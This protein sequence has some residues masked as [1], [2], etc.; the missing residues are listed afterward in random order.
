MLKLTKDEKASRY[1]ALQIAIKVTLESYRR[2]QKD[3]EIRF[4]EA[5]HDGIVGAYTKGQADAFA[6]IVSDLER[7]AE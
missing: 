7:W 3:S 2:R 6:L 4:D 1:D 5:K